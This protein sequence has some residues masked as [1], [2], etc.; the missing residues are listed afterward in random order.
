MQHG[1]KGRK[2]MNRN[3][4]HSMWLPDTAGGEREIS[5]APL[6]TSDVKGGGERL[7]MTSVKNT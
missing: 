2:Q 7:G 3:K 4:K 1:M 6:H 5:S